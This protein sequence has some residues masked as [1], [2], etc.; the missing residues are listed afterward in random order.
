[1]FR[2]WFSLRGRFSYRK[3]L[4][5]I[6]VFWIGFDPVIVVGSTTVLLMILKFWELTFVESLF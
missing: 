4:L 1:M 3:V 6:S 5:K 2:G